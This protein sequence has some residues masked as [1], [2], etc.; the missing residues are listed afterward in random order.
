MN[1]LLT[2]LFGSAFVFSLVYFFS[3]I[4]KTLKNYKE[5]IENF[6][7]KSEQFKITTEDGYILSLWH[8]IPDFPVNK[9]KVVFLQPGFAAIGVCYF[10]LGEKSLPYLLQEEGYDVWIGNNRGTPPSQSHVSKNPN[11]LNGDYWD[12]SMDDYIRY[13]IVSE[14]SYIKNYTKSNKVNFIGYSEGSTLFLMLYMDNPKFVE[15]SINKFVSIGTVPNL[16]DIPNSL[17]KLIDDVIFSLKITEKVSKVFYLNDKART[18]L[19]KAMEKDPTYVYNYFLKGGS[20]TSRV[21]AKGLLHFL[22]YYPADTSIYN[23]YQW[24]NIIDNKKLV[25]YNPNSDKVKEYDYNVIK[26][27]KIKSFIT[28]STTDSF[29]SYYEVTKFYETIENKSLIT[30]FDSD[31]S[32]LDYGLVESAYEEFYIP[33]VQFLE[34]EH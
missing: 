18:A 3:S 32:H 21:T 22:S 9:E 10:E 8:L 25:Y 7:H 30:I 34:N 16:S 5:Y 23:L 28:R 19:I 14:I 31:Y 27:W 29:S 2:I 26:K 6:G 12:F 13:D 11:K 33:L 1:Y 17:Y 15:S 20:I 4:N 24:K